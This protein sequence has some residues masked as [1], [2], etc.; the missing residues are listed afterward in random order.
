VPLYDGRS[1]KH[2]EGFN[3]PHVIIKIY[4]YVDLLKE[5]LTNFRIFLHNILKQ[6][7]PLQADY[8]FTK[9]G[10]Q[11]TKG[12]PIM[13]SVEAILRC[14]CSFNFMTKNAVLFSRQISQLICIV[15]HS[16]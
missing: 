7:P 14:L 11:L 4:E 9:L 15:F 2:Y 5:K 3:E 6:L 1:V 13:F 12:L 8:N 10:L 16:L